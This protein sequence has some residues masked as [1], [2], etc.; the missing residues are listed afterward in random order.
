[1]SGC[2]RRYGEMFSGGVEERKHN[3]KQEAL[4]FV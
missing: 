1:M 3:S 4:R 2:Q